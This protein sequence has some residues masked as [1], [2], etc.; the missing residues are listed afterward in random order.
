[1]I[2]LI[3]RG[4]RLIRR[5]SISSF[6]QLLISKGLMFVT[7]IKRDTRDSTI[8]AATRYLF[9]TVQTLPLFMLFFENNVSI[10]RIILN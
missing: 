9:F 4:T 6:V 7:P 5:I 3:S 10:K 2:M 1:M 8:S